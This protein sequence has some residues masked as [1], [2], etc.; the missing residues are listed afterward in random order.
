MPYYW[1]LKIGRAFTTANGCNTPSEDVLTVFENTGYQGRSI[2]FNT[3]QENIRLPFST[4][5]HS[6]KLRVG[7][8]AFVTYHCDAEFPIIKRYL[9]SDNAILIPAQNICKIDIRPAS[10]FEGTQLRITTRCGE[11]D[12]RNY[13]T[14]HFQVNFRD[15]TSLSPIL[16][17]RG[18]AGGQLATQEFGLGRTVRL[19]DIASVSIIHNGSPN[20]NPFDGGDLFHTYDNWNL[21]LLQVELLI[22][23]SAAQNIFD[24]NRHLPDTQPV[25][26]WRNR[27]WRFTGDIRRMNFNTQTLDF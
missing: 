15:G 26:N 12:L 14:A 21:S 27:E 16:L 11:D 20:N 23:G 10:D 7:F 1:S 5:R 22:T 19:S 25:K 18:L 24:S 8:V 3:S 6:I 9:A 13:N 2:G 17:H 4:D